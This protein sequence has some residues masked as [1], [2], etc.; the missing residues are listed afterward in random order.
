MPH[1]KRQLNIAISDE[2]LRA[3]QEYCWKRRVKPSQILIKHICACVKEDPN[4]FAILME[5]DTNECRKSTRPTPG[6]PIIS[7]DTDGVVTYRS[8]G[9]PR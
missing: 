8:Q 2:L 7:V 9:P 1:R 3:F 5:G 6:R 4:A